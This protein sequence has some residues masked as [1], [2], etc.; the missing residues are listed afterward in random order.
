MSSFRTSTTARLSRILTG[1][2]VWVFFPLI[3]LAAYWLGGEVALVGAAVVLPTLWGALG[4]LR[5]RAE[6]L[7]GDRDALTGAILRESHRYNSEP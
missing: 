4:Q 1:P 2:N 3:S 6:H 5:P 7:Y